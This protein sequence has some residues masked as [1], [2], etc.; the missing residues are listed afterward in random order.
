MEKKYKVPKTKAGAVIRLEKLRTTIEKHRYLYHVLDRSDISPEALDSLKRELVEIEDIYP[1][2]VTPD[3]PSKRVAGEALSRFKKVSHEV[4]QWSFND[5]F[6]I[7]GIR[8][9][10]ARVKRFLKDAYGSVVTPTYTCELKIDGLKLVL[11]Y[12]EGK[13]KVGA[14]RG[15]GKVGEDVTMNA[16]TIESVPIMLAEK[17]TAIVEGEVFMSKTEFER[18]NKERVKKGEEPFANPRNIAAG[19]MRQLDPRIASERKLDIF[20][21]DIG[22]TSSYFPET[23][24][25]ELELLKQLGHNFLGPI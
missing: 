10:D 5:A 3:S 4:P 6:D 12:E 11:T 17:V 16:R 13:L 9:F 18:Q 22:A 23:Q 8:E 1:D 24:I 20:V 19:S 15:D 2:L 7:G 21:Y 14:T 25:A